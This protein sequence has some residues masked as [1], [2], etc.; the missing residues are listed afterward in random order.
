MLS[1]LSF[2]HG[3]ESDLKRGKACPLLLPPVFLLVLL[4]CVCAHVCVCARVCVCVCVCACVLCVCVCACARMRV[5]VCFLSVGP[6]CSH[7][8]VS[9]KASPLKVVPILKYATKISPEQTS[10]RTK[11]FKHVAIQTGQE[12]LLCECARGVR[13]GIYICV[14][15]FIHMYLCIHVTV[16]ACIYVYVREAPVRFGSVTV[17]G[18]NGSSGSGFRFRR[19]LYGGAFCVFQYSLAEMT[20]P[21][22]VSVP[23][24]SGSGGSGSAFGSWENGSDGSGSQFRF[25]SWA[26]LICVWVSMCVCECMA[27]GLKD[28]CWIVGNARML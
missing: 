13:V 16:C 25:G 14:C 17:R 8:C 11:W 4:L 9:L 10:I 2:R 19:F 6:K 12:H 24:S 5:G 27:L 21:V 7:R 28:F 1:C 22:P 15:R 3:V 20:V 26:I 18:W 23:G